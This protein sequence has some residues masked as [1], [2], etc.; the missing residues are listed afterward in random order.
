M[1][2]LYH[3]IHAVGAERQLPEE[4]WLFSRLLELVGATRSDVWQYYEGLSVETFTRMTRALD[5]LRLSEIAE[6]F[7]F[8]HIAWSG[9]DQASS[10][11]E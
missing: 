6:K 4:F 7:R 5:Q 3:L 2:G 10:L 11:D 1:L 8:G 9:P